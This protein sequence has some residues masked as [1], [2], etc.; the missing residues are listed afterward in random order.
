MIPAFLLAAGAFGTLPAPT[1]QVEASEVRTLGIEVVME[2]SETHF[3]ADNLGL[4][5]YVMVLGTAEHGPLSHTLLHAGTSVDFTFPKG[6]LDGVFVEFLAPH[7][8]GWLATGAMPLGELAQERPTSVWLQRSNEFLNA[9]IERVSG[10]DLW[11]SMGALAP[12]SPN[13]PRS[14][15]KRPT[16]DALHVPVVDPTDDPDGDKPPVLEEK[17]LPPV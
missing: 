6:L 16:H 1:H 8:A 5:D 14:E 11:S 7:A 15:A 10:F 12:P 2:V 13:R 17:P 9:W 4:R 3:Q